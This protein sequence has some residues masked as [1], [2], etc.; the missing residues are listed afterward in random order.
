VW[1]IFPTSS[2]IETSVTQRRSQGDE[3]PSGRHTN[4][5]ETIHIEVIDLFVGMDPPNGTEKVLIT[6]R[7]WRTGY[8]SIINTHGEESEVCPLVDIDG[9]A[10]TP[11]SSEPTSPVDGEDYR[12]RAARIRGSDVRKQASTEYLSV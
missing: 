8:E 6:C 3:V 2:T 7:G 12:E 1:L 10:V 11:V 9:A 5:E 4:K